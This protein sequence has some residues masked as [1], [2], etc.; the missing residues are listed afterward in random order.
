LTAADQEHPPVQEAQAVTLI[1][2][3]QRL[4]NVVHLCVQQAKH[5]RL[6]LNIAHPNARDLATPLHEPLQMSLL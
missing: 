4:F 1:L 3:Q 5:D 2:V 6:T